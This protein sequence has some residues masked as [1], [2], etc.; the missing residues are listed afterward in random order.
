MCLWVLLSGFNCRRGVAWL[1]NVGKG[2]YLLVISP[3][4]DA[5][6]VT[7]VMRDCISFMR[8]YCPIP[9]LLDETL[10]VLLLFL[11]RTNPLHCSSPVCGVQPVTVQTRF[12]L[13][14]SLS[15]TW[16]TGYTLKRWEHTRCLLILTS[17]DSTSLTYSTIW[18]RR[19]GMHGV[20]VMC[21]WVCEGTNFG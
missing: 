13:H 18:E 7:K 10:I 11:H 17:M 14:C 2:G 1:G 19:T 8:S 15:S 5:Q 3:Y 21:M 16:V 9:P 4:W 12:V 6:M 20:G